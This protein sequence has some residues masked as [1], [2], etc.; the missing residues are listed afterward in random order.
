MDFR[1]S[2]AGYDINCFMAP[3]S[4]TVYYENLMRK[5]FLP[6]RGIQLENVPENLLSFYE[7]LVS[8]GWTC[9]SQNHTGQMRIG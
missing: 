3:E 9:F 1:Y 4:E 6:E 8:M 7:R 2:M 5:K